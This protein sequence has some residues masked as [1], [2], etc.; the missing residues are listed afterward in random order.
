MGPKKRRPPGDHSKNAKTATLVVM[1]T[2][3]RDVGPDGRPKLSGPL[4]QRIHASFMRHAF[5]VARREAI[6]GGFGP[7]SGKRIQFVNDGDPDLDTY[8]KEYFADYEPSLLLTT[9]DLPHVLEYVWGAASALFEEGAGKL[10]RW[11]GSR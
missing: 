4:N 7:E 9:S 2:L 8:R 10:S 11:V 1:Y 3:R 5:E 6:K